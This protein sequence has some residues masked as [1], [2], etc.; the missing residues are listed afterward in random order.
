MAATA[1]CL[2]ETLSAAQAATTES[3]ERRMSLSA[4][5]RDS[6]T[7]DSMTARVCE[8]ACV[9]AD[10]EEVGIGHW[11]S[12]RFAAERRRLV[13]NIVRAIVQDGIGSRDELMVL[14]RHLRWL[15]VGRGVVG[16][17]PWGSYLM[18]LR[19]LQLRGLVIEGSASDGEDF[20]RAWRR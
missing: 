10:E 14:D 4:E 19:R 20:S 16:Q 3:H 13:A 18:R 2:E 15:C 5:I 1:R 17:M 9:E 11:L 7:I 8:Q 6:L 12:A